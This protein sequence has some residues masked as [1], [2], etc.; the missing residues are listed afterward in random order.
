MVKMRWGR[1]VVI[2]PALA[3]VLCCAAMAL[4]F[5][6]AKYFEAA[7]M[8]TCMGLNVWTFCQIWRNT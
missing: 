3:F 2:V 1:L 8:F 5:G 6:K 7:A 4:A